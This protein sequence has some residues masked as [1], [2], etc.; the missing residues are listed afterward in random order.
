M[1]IDADGWEHFLHVIPFQECWGKQAGGRSLLIIHDW[2]DET[3][4]ASVKT[5]KEPVQILPDEFTTL[6]QGK[7]VFR[8][9]TQ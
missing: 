3:W 2:S 9:F 8:R 6:E 5:G 1:T 7:A 4:A